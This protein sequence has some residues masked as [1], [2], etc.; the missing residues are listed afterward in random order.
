MIEF[1]RSHQILK[2]TGDLTIYH[3]AEAKA[4]FGEELA[5]D[6]AMD[7]DLSDVE[8]MDTAGA[9]L[10]LWLK[11]EGRNRGRTIA[12]SHHSPAV[13]EVLDQLDLAAAFG[14]TLLISPNA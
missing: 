4:R 11:R 8:E 2:V 7:I 1:E 10:L 5:R 6:P 14:D 9:Q 13:L 3:A 12:F